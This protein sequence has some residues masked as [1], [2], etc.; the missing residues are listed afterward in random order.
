[1]AK[2]NQ[3]PNFTTQLQPTKFQLTFAR[4][5]NIT[6]YCQTF[7]LP[8]LSTNEIIR[9]TPFVDLYVPG[10][11]IQYEPFDIMFMIDEDLRTWL[12][13]HNW[14]VGLTFPQ[15]FDQYRRLIKENRDYGGTVSDAIMTVLSNNNQP[16][17]RFT[18]RDCFPINL[19]AITF[20]S[21]TDANMILTASCTLRYNYFD[22]DIL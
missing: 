17:I 8:G 3:K 21:T 13:I 14:M 9:N 11:K 16:N 19:S 15:N 7:T 5:P 6:Y 4:L 1:M 12:E 22:V 20:D 18:F 10:D 2:I